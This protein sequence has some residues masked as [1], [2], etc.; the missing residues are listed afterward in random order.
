LRSSASTFALVVLLAVAAA[1]ARA[2]G[3]RAGAAA[4]ALPAPSGGPLG[5]Y[6]GLSD[7][8]ATGTLDPPQARALV[9]ARDAERI[10]LVTIDVVIVRPSLRDEI[11]ARTRDLRLSGL[12]V[13]ATHTHSG[14]GG[15]VEG[16]LGE[17]MTAG[18]FDPATPGRLAD[19]ASA[20]L[21]A[22]GAALAPVRVGAASGSLDL[23]RNRRHPGGPRETALPVLELTT[24][25]GGRVA[26]VFAYGVHGVA[27]GPAST[28]YSADLL[29]VA[30]ATL[31]GDGGVSL[32][33]P[34]PLGD[35][36]PMFESHHPWPE[37]VDEQEEN[38]RAW[39]ERM[40]EAVRATHPAPREASTLALR[41]EWTDVEPLRL[42]PGS[43]L[44]WLS[45]LVAAQAEHF[46]PKRT[47]FQA[48]R[49]G[50]ACLLLFPAE[51][52]TAIGDAA[53]RLAPPGCL[54]F[55]VAHANDW[56]GYAVTPDDYATGGY[57]ADLSLSG[58]DFGAWLLAHAAAVARR[59]GE[60]ASTAGK[61]PPP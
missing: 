6:G 42:R 40:A 5:G 57:E 14:P 60:E 41:E 4:V 21:H 11:L 25:A 29:G 18:R 31:D 1:P 30:R 53:R 58:Q 54:P 35:Q 44:W 34:G 49:V 39:G 10:G 26:R 50:D 37:A 22:A 56:L 8:L 23:A 43:A 9:V 2:E 27:L 32:F 38:A 15:Y 20:A 55:V 24:P 52:A 61:A 45:P 33:L 48:L 3:L 13:V 51:P 12:V 46:L 36:N 47:L 16:W 59:L 19:A 28:R 17:R 7:R